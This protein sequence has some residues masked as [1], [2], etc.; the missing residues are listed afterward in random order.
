MHYY[1]VMTFG[2]KNVGAT[3]M[4]VMTVLF[5]DMIHKEIEVYVDDVVI[6]SK[7]NSYHLDDLRRFFKRLRQYNLKLNPANCAFGV[8]TGKI[9]G[10]HH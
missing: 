6:K 10:I 5:H 1:R 8:P 3:Y 4:R 2:H 7:I 9:I